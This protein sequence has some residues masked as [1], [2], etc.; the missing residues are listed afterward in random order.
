MRPPPEARGVRVSF[1]LGT[2][3]PRPPPV[4]PAGRAACVCSAQSRQATADQAGPGAEG[5]AWPRT[6]A[7]GSEEVRR[8]AVGAK[9]RVPN[10]TLCA[11]SG[12]KGLLVPNFKAPRESFLVHL[13][14][15]LVSVWVPP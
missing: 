15:G 12:G 4:D 8:A 13:C 3:K 6:G 5:G 14:W 9:G 10:P 7:W 11:K 1:H 2:P